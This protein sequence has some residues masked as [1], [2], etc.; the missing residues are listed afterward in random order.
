MDAQ[1]DQ[2]R[3]PEKSRTPTRLYVLRSLSAGLLYAIYALKNVKP[4]QCSFQALRR[5]TNTQG[6]LHYQLESP[7]GND[8]DSIYRHSFSPESLKRKALKRKVLKRKALKRKAL[9]RKV[10]KRK[11]LRRKA[12]RRKV[13]KRKVLERKVC[14]HYNG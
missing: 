8:D 1:T 2:K 9:R 14:L 3:N 13:L 7:L 6:P 12:L 5:Q 4:N 10:L 11:A